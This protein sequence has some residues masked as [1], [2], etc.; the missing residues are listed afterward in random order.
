MSDELR[1]LCNGWT[2]Q[3][4]ATYVIPFWNRFEPVFIEFDR[5]IGTGPRPPMLPVFLEY[6]VQTKFDDLIQFR[7]DKKFARRSAINTAF[8]KVLNKEPAIL[9]DEFQENVSAAD[10]HS[11]WARLGPRKWTDLTQIEQ[12]QLLD[13]FAFRV[14]AEAYQLEKSQWNPHRP[15]EILI[16]ELKE[17]G[18]LVVGGKF[19]ENAYQ[20]GALINTNVTIAGRDIYGFR[21]GTHLKE[22]CTFLHTITIIGA[23]VAETKGD[24][25][26]RGYVYYVDPDDGSDP[27]DLSKQRIFK[28]SYQS[29]VD[30]VNDLCGERTQHES[31]NGYAWAAK[32]LAVGQTYSLE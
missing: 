25:Y 6:I 31:E 22:R 13:Y 27:K 2:R 29:L 11:P 18:P 12:F 4:V 30:N 26:Y 10:L 19:G 20:D 21:V 5:V 16:A 7:E 3:Y 32:S 24:P 9:F 8:L 17:R 28:I 15:I 23:E 1:K 14:S